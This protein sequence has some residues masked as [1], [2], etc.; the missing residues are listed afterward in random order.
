MASLNG[1]VNLIQLS[2]RALW[3]P[4]TFGVRVFIEDS[5]GR[6]VL[7]RHSYLAGWFLPGGGVDRGE[8]PDAAA[9]REAR[10]EAGVTRSAPPEFFG[11]YVQPVRWITNIVSIYRLRDAEIEFHPN[12]EIRELMWADPHAPPDGMT[13]GTLRR[14]AEFTGKMAKSSKW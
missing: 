2:V 9:V 6:I 8:L 1:A 4:V 12:L 13:P 7:I 10:E 5:Q 3:Q 11:Q 14:L